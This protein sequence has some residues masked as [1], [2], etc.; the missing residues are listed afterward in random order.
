M[1]GAACP[2]KAL[3][4]LS[5]VPVGEERSLSLHE[6]PWGDAMGLLCAC[7]DNWQL[8]KLG[9]KKIRPESTN[10]TCYK[11]TAIYGKTPSASAM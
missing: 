11:P 4:K 10:Q 3:G 8:T 7:C 9:K 5:F 1:G 2:D 6:C